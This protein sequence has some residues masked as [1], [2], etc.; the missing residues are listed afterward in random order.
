MGSPELGNP[1][2]GRLNFN[3]IKGLKGTRS[4]IRSMAFGSFPGAPDLPFL[5]SA[6]V[7]VPPSKDLISNKGAQSGTQTVACVPCWGSLPLGHSGRPAREF[8]IGPPKTIKGHRFT[9]SYRPANSCAFARSPCPAFLQAPIHHHYLAG[10]RLSLVS[11]NY[12]FRRSFRSSMRSVFNEVRPS[13]VLSGKLKN[14]QLSCLIQ[15]C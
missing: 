2:A 4:S 11:A 7:T 13:R 5:F 10:F 14:L 12:R 6:S 3:A 8:V 9:P 15:R 1:S